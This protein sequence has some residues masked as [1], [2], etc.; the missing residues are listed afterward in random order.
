MQTEEQRGK[1]LRKLKQNLRD[2]WTALSAS[3]YL[4]ITLTPNQTKIS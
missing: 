3:A 2:L 1:K 4:G